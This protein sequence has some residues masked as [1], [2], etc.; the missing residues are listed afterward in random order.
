MT[1]PQVDKLS[2]LLQRVQE[3]RMPRA[4]PVGARGAEASTPQSRERAADPGAR[5]RQATPVDERAIRPVEAPPAPTAPVAMAPARRTG[6]DRR[7]TPLEMAFTGELDRERDAPAAPQ[8]KQPVAAP[9]PDARREA[10]PVAQPAME[11]RRGAAPATATRDA[12]REPAAPA[13]RA[14]TVPINEP[15][16]AQEIVPR[17]IEPDPPRELGRPIAQVVSR[18][19][20]PADATFGAMLKRSLSLR[21]H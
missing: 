11:S 4:A 19:A 12:R 17:V 21:P 2:A 14:A 10:A 5:A 7:A 3:N 9:A 16:A 18:H 13:A 8:P 20:P 1:Q 6:Q 15:I